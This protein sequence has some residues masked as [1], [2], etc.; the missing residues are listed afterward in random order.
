MNGTNSPL[1][2][3]LVQLI[4]VAVEVIPIIVT[5]SRSPPS[6]S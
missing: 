6:G 1:H 3:E 4:V 2:A 5:S